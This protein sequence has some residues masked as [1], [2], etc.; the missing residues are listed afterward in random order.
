MAAPQF[1]VINLS[2]PDKN[3]GAQSAAFPCSP[4]DVIAFTAS[5]RFVAGGMQPFIAVYFWDALQET[6]YGA[7]LIA[8]PNTDNGWHNYTF[9]YQ[10]PTG[11]ATMVVQTQCAYVGTVGIVNALTTENVFHGN[12]QVIPVDNTTDML[13]GETINISGSSPGTDEVIQAVDTGVSFTANLAYGYAAG[14]SVVNA[15]PP[16]S[17]YFV[18]FLPSGFTPV[19]PGEPSQTTW[20]ISNYRLTQNGNPVYA[21]LLAFDSGLVGGVTSVSI[22]DGGEDYS[23]GD[24]L[25]P[26]QGSASGCLI[27]VTAVAYFSPNA[28]GSVQIIAAGE[29][30]STADDVPA[31]GGTGSGAEFDLT[32]VGY[33]QLQ[34]FVLPLYYLSLLTS[35]YQNA[36][37]LYAWLSSLLIV[38]VD[39]FACTQQLYQQFSLAGVPAVAPGYPAISGQ[40]PDTTIAAGPQLDIIGTIVGFNR[41]LPFQ[42]GV[43]TSLSSAVAAGSAV[44]ADIQ[45]LSATSAPPGN[46]ATSGMYVP[47]QVVVTA[48]GAG[49]T[50]ETVD[51]I[52]YVPGVSFTANFVH[53]H[54]VGA[55]VT[56]LTPP[57]STLD[58]ADYITA[59]LAKIDRNQFNG[60]IDSIYAMLNSLFPGS[61]II[62]IDNANMTVDV[63]LTGGTLTPIQEQMI[64]NDLILPR[65]Q[66]VLYIFEYAELP[67]FGADLNN[68]FI[69]GADLGHAV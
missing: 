38:A 33:V 43:S 59:L 17:T 3:I 50:T 36:P 44:V 24:V 42:P 14:A 31:T 20:E 9:T 6:S 34:E 29:G 23:V 25:T 15:F 61:G 54:G 8:P 39:L 48:E 32:T 11:A 62:L 58:D 57:S 67:V 35:E 41:T 64:I 60:Q 26:T 7:I 69:A 2:A 16:S 19:T 65:P 66:G 13:V 30:Y 63:L 12:S 49:S 45:P 4:G 28:I 10:V 21:P 47:L 18:G 37:N 68:A 52:S 5:I 55:K 51:I 53:P 40:P 56:S 27:L 46:M 1:N 22:A